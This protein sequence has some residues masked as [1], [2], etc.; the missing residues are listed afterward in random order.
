M[1]FHPELTGHRSLPVWYDCAD[2][3]AHFTTRYRAIQSTG[4][5]RKLKYNISQR[6]TER[7]ETVL[8]QF[9]QRLNICMF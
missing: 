4:K 9:S 5:Q 6:D 7:E 1:V 3:G 8:I 2:P